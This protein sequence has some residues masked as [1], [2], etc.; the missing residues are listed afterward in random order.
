MNIRGRRLLERRFR[1]W[2]AGKALAA[3]TAATLLGLI[4]HGATRPSDVGA[5]G[6]T[7][8]SADCGF[9]ASGGMASCNLPASSDPNV[10][11]TGQV[12]ATSEPTLN[13]LILQSTTVTNNSSSAVTVTINFSATFGGDT[14]GRRYGITLN[15]NFTASDGISIASGGAVQLS[16][17][18]NGSPSPF[19]VAGGCSTASGAACQG[20]PLSYDVSATANGS[21]DPSF[22]NYGPLNPDQIQGPNSAPVEGETLK[23]VVTMT[24]QAGQTNSLQGSA[25]VASVPGNDPSRLNDLLNGLKARIDADLR[26]DGLIRVVLTGLD[27]HTVQFQTVRLGGD[28]CLRFGCPASL[29]GQPRIRQHAAILQFLQK[30]AQLRCTD[31]TVILTGVVKAPDGTLSPFSTSDGIPPHCF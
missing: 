30:D 26:G 21:V 7:T 11:V 9:V 14:S 13:H 31:K 24:L 15:G 10:V 28:G 22:N 3:L 1:E 17:F 20:Q 18:V 16:G 4:V 8:V 25:H 23:G 29:V 12:V 2:S 27:P 5:Y 19:T 6:G